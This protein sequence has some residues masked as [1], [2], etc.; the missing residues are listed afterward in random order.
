MSGILRHNLAQIADARVSFL[1][2]SGGGGTGRDISIMLSGSDPV[3]LNQTASK[4]VDEMSAL[5]E[6]RAAV[7]ADLK[8]RNC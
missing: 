8:R 3:L 6:I 2:Q 7:N 5:K 4:L 1:S